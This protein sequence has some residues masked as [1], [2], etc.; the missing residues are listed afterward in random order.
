MK[1]DLFAVI[2]ALAT[3]IVAGFVAWSRYKEKKITAEAELA[4]NPERCKDHETRLR[5]I[6]AIVIRLDIRVHDALTVI[7]DLKH[8]IQK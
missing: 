6:E 5:A 1:I 7:E 4:D 8:A 2:N 3:L